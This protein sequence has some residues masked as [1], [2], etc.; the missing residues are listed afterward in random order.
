MTYDTVL[1]EDQPNVGDSSI[2]QNRLM[3]FQP[4]YQLTNYHNYKPVASAPPPGNSPINIPC[5]R[6]SSTQTASFQVNLE[7]SKDQQ[8]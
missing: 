8:D 6:D 3:V 2:W 7:A 4:G 1:Y 5:G